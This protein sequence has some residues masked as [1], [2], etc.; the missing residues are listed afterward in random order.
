MSVGKEAGEFSSTPNGGVSQQ[1]NLEGTASGFG[2]VIGT[3]TFYAAEPGSDRGFV[4]WAGP[5]VGTEREG[6][7]SLCLTLT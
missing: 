4:T 5:G 1:V 2:S 6:Q 3:L 7:L